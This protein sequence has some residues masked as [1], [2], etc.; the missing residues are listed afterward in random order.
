M[1]PRMCVIGMGYIGIP[2]AALFANNGFKVTGVDVDENKLLE[3]THGRCPIDEPG[4][5]DLIVKG[6]SNGCLKFS[7]KVPEAEVYAICVPTPV[8]LNSSPDG[9]NIPKPDMSHVYAVVRQLA[10]I[11]PDNSL[12]LLESTSPVGTTRKIAEQFADS[13]RDLGSM[14]FAYCPERVLPGNIIHELK[15]NTRIVGGLDDIASK[16]AS[17]IYKKIVRGS[18]LTC[19]AE[20]AEMC[21]LVENS[22][23]DLNIA[24][25]NELS[26]ICHGMGV[27][28]KQLIK[29]ANFH[30]RVNILEPGIGVGGHCIPVD[31][32]FIAS[33][34][35][36]TTRMIQSA[37]AV[38]LAKTQWVKDLIVD[39]IKSFQTEHS[40]NPNVALFGL[41]YKPNVSDLRGSPALEIAKA[42]TTLYPNVM[43]VEPLI[44][45]NSEVRMTPADVA[46]KN[47]DLAIILVAHDDF[48]SLFAKPTPNLAVL[49]LC[50]CLQG[51]VGL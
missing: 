2:T 8:L 14:S 25:A 33:R 48:K 3:L 19:A 49:D 31:P 47:L 50:D 15:N 5:K 36:D 45:A 22:Y 32:W 51:K 39:E 20:I 23:R 34:F 9:F 27:D 28:V 21:K 12:V 42:I 40:R 7:H 10:D 41:A 38:N 26:M 44:G 4:L 6:Q 29:L 24:F 46:I 37:R 18:V 16:R 17:D 35:P 13:G 1:K 11:A 43:L 30:P